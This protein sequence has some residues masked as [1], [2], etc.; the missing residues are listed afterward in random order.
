MTE[1]KVPN[2]TF[3][4]YSGALKAYEADDK[5][6]LKTVASSTIKDLSG[7]TMTENA[8]KQMADSARNNMTIFLN[9]SYSVPEDVFGSV[10]DVQVVQRGEFV[11][12][13]FDISLNDSN[14]RAVQTWEAISKGTKLGTSIG[15]KILD[16]WSDK[17]TGGYVF[18]SVELLEASIVGIP[19]NPRSWVEYAVKSLTEPATTTIRTAI[20]PDAEK[21][22]VWVDVSAD[23]SVS[24]TVETDPP[25]DDGKKKKKDEEPEIAKA[26]EAKDDRKAVDAGKE[27]EEG[28][29]MP[30]EDN[31]PAQSTD[32]DNHAEQ[33]TVS[34]VPT[35]Q[36][37]QKSV[38]ETGDGKAPVLDHDL[39][40]LLGLKAALSLLTKTTGELVEAKK[41]LGDEMAAHAVTKALLVQ[42]K[43]DQKAMQAIIEKV[44]SLPIGRRAAFEGEVTSFRTQ[45]AHMYDENF[46]KML[47][48]NSND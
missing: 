41:A 14:P 32:T 11:D 21:A 1:P 24:S 8:I 44:S 10:E 42:V 22:T 38:P 9:H 23:G 12:L 4:I 25:A 46:L 28:D 36:E 37:A 48:N 15:A 13:D 29:L 39:E 7:D 33:T 16:G 5:R 17:A 20:T 6:R 47:E 45:F 3:K 19:A 26:E 18:D 30:T 27:G 40:E 2:S 43:R 31:T 35:P 34:P